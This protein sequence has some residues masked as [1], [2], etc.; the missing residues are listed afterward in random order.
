MIPGWE[1][2]TEDVCASPGGRLAQVCQLN[3]VNNFLGS[4]W[5]FWPPQGGCSFSKQQLEWLRRR[6]PHE[7]GPSFSGCTVEGLHFDGKKYFGTDS[8][9]DCAQHCRGFGERRGAW[10]LAGDIK[11]MIAMEMERAGNEL[12]EAGK[13]QINMGG[14]VSWEES[15]FMRRQAM[16]CCCGEK[17]RNRLKK[18]LMIWAWVTGSPLASA[19]K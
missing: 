13:T 8:R 4:T 9:K 17:G 11:L 1:S 12:K 2:G 18:L 15:K 6:P 19:W 10:R 7:V 16:P 3:Y 5:N 14:F